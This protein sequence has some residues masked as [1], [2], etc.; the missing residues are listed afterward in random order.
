MPPRTVDNLGLDVSTRYAEDQKILDQSLITGAKQIP[1][2]VEIDV[3]T[4][5]FPAELIELLGLQPA[6]ITW[7]CFTPP[8]QYNEQRKRLFTYQII[9]SMGSEDKQEAQ[10]QKILAK[11]QTHVEQKEKR[12][13]AVL[14]KRQEYETKRIRDEE[15]KEKKVLT[16]LLNTIH[17]FD[18]LIIDINSRRN[19]YQK[20]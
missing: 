18:K 15:E 8:A 10:V 14:D 1:S 11:I 20:G 5:Y 17:K 6:G 16:D 2:Q 13:E 12:E 3:S 7:A 4:P 19:Q 9:P